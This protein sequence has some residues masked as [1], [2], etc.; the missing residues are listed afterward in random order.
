M[1]HP[2][3]SERA[4]KESL[5]PLSKR[6]KQLEWQIKQHLENH[7]DLKEQSELLQTISGIGERTAHLLLSELGFFELIFKTVS[8]RCVILAA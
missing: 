4:S 5:T 3:K 1:Y 8:T 6:I 7:P 2:N